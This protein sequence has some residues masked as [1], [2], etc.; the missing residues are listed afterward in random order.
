[1]IFDWSS[2]RPGVKARNSI[3]IVHNKH[4]ILNETVKVWEML[5]EMDDHPRDWLLFAHGQR[6]EYLSLVTSS[7]TRLANGAP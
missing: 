7:P 3:A 2:D 4:R 6:Q 5:H 1:M